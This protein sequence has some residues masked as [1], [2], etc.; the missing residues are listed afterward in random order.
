[1]YIVSYGPRVFSFNLEIAV[2]IIIV[3][4]TCQNARSILDRHT[5]GL[6]SLAYESLRVILCEKN[7]KSSGFS[8]KSWIQ[9]R[10][11]FVEYFGDGRKSL[12]TETGV[13]CSSAVEKE[14]LKA[15]HVL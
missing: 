10:N 12:G 14:I 3:T 15:R 9:W 5:I 13:K 6:P 2:H 7:G 8:R 11:V 4:S 1:M